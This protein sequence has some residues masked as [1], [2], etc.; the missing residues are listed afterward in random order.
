MSFLPERP[1]LFPRKWES[2]IFMDPRF[3]G[4]DWFHGN[5]KDFD[6]AGINEF[7]VL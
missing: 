7:P 3:H 5:D 1:M 6:M 4:D 2:R